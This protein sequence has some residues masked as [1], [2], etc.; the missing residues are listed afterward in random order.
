[1]KV[2]IEVNFYFN[3]TFWKAQEG[4]EQYPISFVRLRFHGAVSREYAEEL[5][6]TEEG[7]YLTRESQRQPGNYALTFRYYS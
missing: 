5:V 3:T 6:M 2:K 1:M 7:C 4:K